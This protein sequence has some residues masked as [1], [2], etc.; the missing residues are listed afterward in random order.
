MRS[1]RRATGKDAPFPELAEQLRTALEATGLS[2]RQIAVTAGLNR[3]TLR[4]ALGGGNITLETLR[5]IAD[6]LDLRVVKI[7]GVEIEVG[8]GRTSP[9]AVLAAASHLQR[10]TRGF[11]NVTREIELAARLLEGLQ[12]ERDDRDRA[13]E[14]VSEI[15]ER[16][17]K[18]EA[19]ARRAGGAKRNV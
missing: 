13:A 3:A 1:T 17:K 2:E 7:A 18:N 12:R 9:A 5:I 15:G 19:P 6:A 11:E 10:A 14:I 4:D 16:A 8:E